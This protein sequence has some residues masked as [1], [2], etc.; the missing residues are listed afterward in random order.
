MPV[1]LPRTVLPVNL[2][3]VIDIGAVVLT[4]S[5]FTAPATGTFWTE[6]LAELL[7]KV[8]PLI[9]RD[10]PGA[11]PVCQYWRAP[12]VLL[13]LELLLKVVLETDS[14]PPSNCRA[15]PGLLES[16]ELTVLLLNTALL[17]VSV[18][19]V[20]AWPAPAM[21]PAPP[22]VV[23]CPWVIVTPEI[24]VVTPPSRLGSRSK[25]RLASLPLMIVLADPDP[26]DVLPPLTAYYVMRVGRLPLVPY[27]D[28]GD[29]A[30]ASAVERLAAE[31]HA[32]LLANHGPVVAGATLGEAQYAIEE[33]EETAKLFLLLRGERLRPLTPEQAEALRK[34]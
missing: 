16:A 25:T 12:A 4:P 27:H 13:P 9:D 32:V 1:P 19:P 11:S 10:S 8:L 23:T 15:P 20:V 31:N 34:R 30:L 6:A 28:P 7:L 18:S 14:E 24:E 5:M 26:D 17:T 3:P 21:M 29:A 2:E 33:L 22:N